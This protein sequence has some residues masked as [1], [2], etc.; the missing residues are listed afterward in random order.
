MRIDPAREQRLESAIDAGATE[1]FLHQRVKAERRQVS[2]V[3]HDRV[4]K[5][6]RPAV[7]GVLGQQI[8]ELLRPFPVADIPR[9]EEVAIQH[10]GIIIRVV[11]IT[12]NGDRFEVAGPLTVAELLARLDVDARRV[13]VEHNLIVLKRT[14]FEATSVCEG[15]AVEIV[16]FVGGG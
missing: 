1:R 16:N 14:A 11:T 5:G 9:H 3:E 4:T 12:V 7:I 10:P 2:F 15:D 6:D 13:A 8:E